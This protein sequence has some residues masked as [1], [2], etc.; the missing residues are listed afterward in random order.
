M[1]RGEYQHVMDLK[2]RVILPQKF[3]EGLGETFIITKG[4]DQCLYVY[5]LEQ[6]EVYEKK[7]QSL[8]IADED[9]RQFMRFFLGSATECEPDGQG[10]VII[11]PALKEY[12]G[13]QKDIVSIGIA[14]KIEIWSAENW[15]TANNPTAKVDP[16]VAQKIAALGF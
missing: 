4:L 2:N 1:F 13:L 10:R 6:W 9:V 11:S 15:R 7:A 8:S 3:R 16:K 14:D 12:A 5:T